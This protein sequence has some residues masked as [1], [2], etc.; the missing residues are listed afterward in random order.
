MVG[1][2]VQYGGG[3]DT[4]LTAEGYLR[5]ILTSSV[6]DVAI[7]TP[8][9]EMPKLSDQI[10]NLILLKREDMQSVF[11]FKLRGAYNK[12]SK[13]SCEQKERGVICSSAGW[14]IFV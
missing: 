4:S 5:R 8:L 14:C 11:S 12:I 10:K 7:E 9:E 2:S 13:L 6:Y 1:S 3:V